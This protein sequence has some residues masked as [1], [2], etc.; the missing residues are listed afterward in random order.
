MKILGVIPA[1]SGSKRVTNKNIKKLNGKPLIAYTIEAALNSNLDQ[2]TVS[3]DSEEIASIS[4]DYGAEIL[5]RSDSLSND[6]APTL[7]V[8]QDA[9]KKINVNFDAVMT[10]QPTSPLRTYLHI[11]QAIKIFMNDIN[12]DSLVSVVKVPHSFIPEKL[13]KYDG[14]YLVDFN[15]PKRSQ[16]L[17]A[18]YARNGAAIYLTKIPKLKEYIFG[19]V[20]L[21]Y[22]MEKE[23]SF[24]IDDEFDWKVI[25]AFI[26]SFSKRT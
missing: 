25:E 15:Q 22:F 13:M 21:P 7:P 17:N 9:V 24:D 5:M 2:V 14:K 18:I 16:D 8:I 20:V 6:L 26:K 19:G 11:N 3:T 4:K 23:D 10:L 12:A 1:R